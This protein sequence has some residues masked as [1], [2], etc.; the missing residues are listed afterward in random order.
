[1]VAF[2]NLFLLSL[3][4]SAQP[5]LT[6]H[7][8][9]G[10]AQG[11]NFRISY[12]SSSKDTI[13][14]QLF[15]SI[16]CRLDSSL[17]VY[18][19]NSLIH[20]FNSTSDTIFCDS[21]LAKV[22]ATAKQIS[23]LTNNVFDITIGA[24]TLLQKF[25]DTTLYFSSKQELSK[26]IGEHYL[27][28]Y[29]DSV[30]K[31]SSC[32]KIDVDGIAQ[33]YSVDVLADFLLINNINNFLI[34]VGGELRWNGTN[35]LSGRNWNIAV[36]IPG[37][38]QWQIDQNTF[39]IQSEK[40]A[41][42]TSGNYRKSLLSNATKSSLFNA[43]TRKTISK[44]RL[45]VTVFSKE[46]IWADALDNAFMGMSLYRIKKYLHA[47]SDVSCLITYKK[48]DKQKLF[49]SKKFPVFSKK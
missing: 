29:K 4:S 20:H 33:G 8:Y 47:N 19:S 32:V 9:S 7:T 44:K 35:L 31:S 48:G 49:I 34:D 6:L 25:H 45:S 43:R 17:S 5:D 42:T 24:L 12:F 38:E 16:F 46:A 37:L 11:T 21:H 27:N 14:V 18:K 3:N 10:K 23:I 40:G 13:R 1:M 26:C 28:V 36:E 39:F 15:D 2:L 22:V 30:S 41:L